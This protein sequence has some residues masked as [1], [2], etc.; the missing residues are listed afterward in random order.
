GG[1]IYTNRISQLVSFQPII[2]SQFQQ[3][4]QNPSQPVIQHQLQQNFQTSSQPVI[5]PQL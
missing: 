3:N 2:Q 5:Q 4:F 1:S